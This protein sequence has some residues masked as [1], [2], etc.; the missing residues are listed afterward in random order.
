M[1]NNLSFRH[2]LKYKRLISGM[3]ARQ[4]SLQAGLSAGYVSKVEAGDI[5]PSLPAFASIVRVLNC[6]DLEI[7]FM[8][9]LVNEVEPINDQ[10]LDVMPAPSE[11]SPGA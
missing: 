4:V 7:I 2:T 5:I 9:G 6:T 10:A 8:I 3:S 1:L 11:T